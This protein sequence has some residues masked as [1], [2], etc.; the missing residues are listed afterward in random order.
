MAVAVIQEF[1]GATLDQY[2]EV[3]ARMGLSPADAGPPGSLFHWVAATD[4]GLLITDVWETQEAFMAFAE[5]SIRPS[6]AAVGIEGEPAI[7]FHEVHNHQ[8]A[9]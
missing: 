4:N 8:T 1:E 3:L 2:D 6:V 9:G 7:T 5:E